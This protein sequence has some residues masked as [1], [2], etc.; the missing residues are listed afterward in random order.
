MSDCTVDQLSLEKAVF[1]LDP[2]VN[3]INT[4]CLSVVCYYTV[5]LLWY[6]NDKNWFFF[7]EYESSQ[8]PQKVC[9]C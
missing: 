4:S 9:Y 6:R 2:Y 7:L 1:S 5:K 3:C 8:Q